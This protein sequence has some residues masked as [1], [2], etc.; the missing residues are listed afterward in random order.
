MRTSVLGLLLL[1]YYESIPGL[2]VLAFNW[3]S[4]EELDDYFTLSYMLKN[5]QFTLI[6]FYF[7]SLKDQ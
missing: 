1:N 3:G 2:Q 5:R 4:S 7:C 6:S